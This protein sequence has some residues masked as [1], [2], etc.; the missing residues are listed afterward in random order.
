MTSKYIPIFFNLNVRFIHTGYRVHPSFKQCCASIFT[1]HNETLNIWTSLLSS[2][3]YIIF[4]IYIFLY[5]KNISLGEM[6]AF[7]SYTFAAIYCFTASAIFHWFNCMSEEIYLT[8]A[9]AD[10]SGIS[11]LIGGSMITPLWYNTNIN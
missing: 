5:W 3:T 4:T 11:L 1:L 10:M 2:F 9:R 8:T 6:L 7:F